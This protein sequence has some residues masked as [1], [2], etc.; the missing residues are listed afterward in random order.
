MAGTDVEARISAAQ[1]KDRLRANGEEAIT[2]GVFGVPTFVIG[3]EL[4]WGV[5]ATQFVI[6]FLADPALLDDAEMQRV[7]TLPIASAR[8][9]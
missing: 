8:S 3:S 6:D 9:R 4:F 2:R 5:D 1:V 7:S